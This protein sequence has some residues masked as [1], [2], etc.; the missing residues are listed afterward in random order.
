M[1]AVSRSNLPSAGEPDSLRLRW[2]DEIGKFSVGSRRRID[3]PAVPCARLVKNDATAQR[4]G[5]QSRGEVLQLKRRGM[6]LC[7]L[8]T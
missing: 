4:L 8:F 5:Q 7:Q 1:I 3:K 2:C 6:E